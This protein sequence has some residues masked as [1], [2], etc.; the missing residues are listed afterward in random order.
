MFA[1]RQSRL[2]AMTFQTIDN[3][4]P[5]NQTLKTNKFINNL[6]IS[7]SPQKIA[8]LSNYSLLISIIT[9]SVDL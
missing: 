8:S 7:Q 4:R 3:R 5:R 2:D 9:L 6:Y 1:L